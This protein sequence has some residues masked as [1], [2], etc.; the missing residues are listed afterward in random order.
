MSQSNQ[1]LYGKTSVPWHG[2]MGYGPDPYTS[3]MDSGPVDG[4]GTY[5]AHTALSEN[6]LRNYLDCP[7]TL[8]HQTMYGASSGPLNMPGFLPTESIHPGSAYAGTESLPGH[9]FPVESS[10]LPHDHIAGGQPVVGWAEQQRWP[11]SSTMPGSLSEPPIEGQS[12]ISRARGHSVRASRPNSSRV[13]KPYKPARQSLNLSPNEL[14]PELLPMSVYSNP[15]PS[16]YSSRPVLQQG[17]SMIADK[18]IDIASAAQAYPALQRLYEPPPFPGSL[19]HTPWVTSPAY[20]A[21][22]SASQDLS[23]E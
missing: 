5:E 18:S 23:S 7:T 15:D 11:L 13:H 19:G 9:G 1:T 16:Q 3:F 21:S 14:L 2:S 22:Y 10:G 20:H 8:S 4:N 12:G 17:D 6:A